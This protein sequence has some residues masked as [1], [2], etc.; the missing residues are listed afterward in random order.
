MCH[1][2]ALACSLLPGQPL[3][4][5]MTTQTGASGV[6]EGSILG[7]MLFLVYINDLLRPSTV[8]NLYTLCR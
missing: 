7:L 1:E 6:P 5:L 2:F 4:S 8:L 3:K